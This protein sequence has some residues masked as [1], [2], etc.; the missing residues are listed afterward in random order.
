MAF[1]VEKTAL[2]QVLSEYFGFACQAFHR[3]LHIHHL[4]LVQ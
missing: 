3:F 1:A 4:G 2:E